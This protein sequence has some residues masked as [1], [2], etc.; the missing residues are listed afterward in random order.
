MKVK[1][2]APHVEVVH[3]SGTLMSRMAG[4][5]MHQV[6]VFT[7]CDRL[8]CAAVSHRIAHDFFVLLNSA[9]QKD[10]VTWNNVHLFCA[11]QC[12]ESTQEQMHCPVTLRTF[13][14]RTNLPATN[15][16]QICAR[17]RSC[18][19]SAATYEETIKRVVSPGSSGV[20]SFDLIL[21]QMSQDGRIT[22]LFPD[23]Y[24]FYESERLVWVSHVIGTGPTYVALTHPLL[25]AAKHVVVSVLGLESAFTLRAIFTAELDAIRYP[26]H[27]LWPVL[28]RVTW[29]VDES[30]A[31]F[32]PPVATSR[33]T[34]PKRHE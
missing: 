20:P 23:T 17:C 6:R 16:H 19:S 14:C 33:P 1:D 3:D 26:V 18:E 27:A 22:S 34:Q 7:D 32:L 8:F 4:F 24:G 30:A 25:Q 31:A 5:F 11:D 9:S 28:D 29:V 15:V 13:A 10:P 2:V 12:G 21:L